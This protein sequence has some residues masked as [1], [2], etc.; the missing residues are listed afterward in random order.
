[1][2]KLVAKISQFGLDGVQAEIAVFR[3]CLGP[4]SEFQASN[5][6]VSG[7]KWQ[8][9]QMHLQATTGSRDYRVCIAARGELEHACIDATLGLMQAN[10]P[11]IWNAIRG[12]RRS[13]STSL[14]AFRLLSREGATTHKLLVRKHML[15]QCAI[16]HALR[17]PDDLVEVRRVF[18]FVADA[19]QC[20]RGDYAEEFITSYADWETNDETVKDMIEELLLLALMIDM[21]TAAVECKHAAVR[22]LK[23]LRSVQTHVPTLET[24]S[25]DKVLREVRLSNWTWLGPSEG[26]PNRR[27]RAEE[28]TNPSNKKTG[29]GGAW[30]C[31]LHSLKERGKG[32]LDMTQ[33][34]EM[35]RQLPQE[36]KEALKRA[37]FAAAMAHRSGAK[38]SF[39]NASCANLDEG[40]EP[41]SKLFLVH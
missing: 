20:L 5:L 2:K 40:Q 23:N 36:R 29:G 35:Y 11:T 1:M 34:A 31:F 24:M 15:M 32:R 9:Q 7:M 17:N 18:R 10:S 21:D 12:I 38:N 4:L 8:K 39:G 27:A 26:V 3:I 30:R 14:F 28:Q 25:Q 6:R 37:G 13:R 41:K 22:R 19:K 16:F 33:C